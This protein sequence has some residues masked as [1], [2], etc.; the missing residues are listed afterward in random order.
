LVVIELPDWAVPAAATPRVVDFGF[1]QEAVGGSMT[2]IERPGSKF[3]VDVSFPLMTAA[4]A[5]VL[6]ARIARARVQ[7]LRIE[8]PLLGESQ[9]NPGTPVVDGTDSAGRVLKLR[10]L[11]LGYQVKEGYWLNLIGP[12]GARYLHQAAALVE[13][14][15]LGKAVLAVEPPLRIFPADGA[16]VELAAPVIE[17][18]VVSDTAWALNPGALVNGIALT[19]REA[20]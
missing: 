6:V 1:V 15:A 13:A 17:G 14:D 11:A 7:G 12:D 9:G 5:R 10:G 16:A 3:E 19:L 8:Y 2:R 4:K 18:L 20:A